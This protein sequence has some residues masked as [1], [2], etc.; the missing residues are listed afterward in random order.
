MN[1]EE[2]IKGIIQNSG[3]DFHLKIADFL[4]S[5]GWETKVSP[6]YNDPAT[7][8]PREID[9]VALK[10]YEVGGRLSRDTEELLAM[11]LFI[12]CKYI[13]DANV[14]W[15]ERKDAESAIELAKDNS[16]LRSL[17]DCNLQDT[18][19]LPVKCHHYLQGSEVMKL[20][21][22]TGNSDPLYEGMNGCLNA[23]VFYKE[24]QYSGIPNI[25][26][27]PVIAINN[28]KNLYKRSLSDPKG[29][30]EIL[31]NFQ[32]EVNYSFIDRRSKPVTR[33]F[34]IDIVHGEKFEDFL[35]MLEKNDVQIMLRQLEWQLHQNKLNELYGGE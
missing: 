29:Y 27:F 20:W 26:D 21:S 4:R 35:M 9:I 6:Y 23:T 15:F 10:K 22:K 17:E 2:K 28:A 14:L 24:Y 3:N 33:Y 16:I 12:E 18:S 1:L 32:M 8:K 31:D 11:R 25:I 5:L 13:K 34:L 19:T 30:E 7:N